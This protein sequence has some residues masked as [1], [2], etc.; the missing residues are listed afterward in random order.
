ALD[1]SAAPYRSHV[2]RAGANLRFT[3]RNAARRV[4]RRR[5]D[6]RHRRSLAS[7][8]YISFEGVQLAVHRRDRA[9]SCGRYH[10]RRRSPVR[11][12]HAAAATAAKTMK[13]VVIVD[14]SPAY[15]QLWAGYMAE[16]Y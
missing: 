12:A 4:A 7:D 10:R 15:C 5:H 3:W 9:G 13:R 6:S 11:F 1:R 14:D 2:I 8:E 16:R